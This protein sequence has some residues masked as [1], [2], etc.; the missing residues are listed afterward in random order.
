MRQPASRPTG[1]GSLLLRIARVVFEPAVIEDVV[2][3]TIA[4]LQREVA[5]AGVHRARRRRAL[6]NGYRAFWTLVLL[7]PFSFVRWTRT[8]SR[9]SAFPDLAE[10]IAFALI[11]VT[12]VSSMLVVAGR[13]T[14]APVLASVLVAIGLHAWWRRHPSLIALPDR[15]R[16]PEINLSSI[17]VGGDIAGLMFVVGSVL[18]VTA[19]IPMVRWFLVGVVVGG[20]ALA[21]VL[22]RWHAS[23]ASRSPTTILAR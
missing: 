12:V 5:A 17:P 6:L 1:P 21:L 19:A 14:L 20:F 7:A 2:Q 9:G 22:T 15:V 13:W 10:R 18:T 23:H 3:P 16:T 8:P 4:D 11:S